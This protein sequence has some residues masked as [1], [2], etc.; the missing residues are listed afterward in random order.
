MG[1]GGEDGRHHGAVARLA[2]RNVPAGPCY[3]H[4]FC[5]CLAPDSDEERETGRLTMQTR[6]DFIQGAASAA[7]AVVFTSCDLLDHHHA[8]AEGARREIV[9][10]GKRVKT[11]DIHAHCA[12]PEANGLLGVK[13]VPGDA[14]RDGGAH[15]VDGRAGHR[16][17]GAEHQ[18]VLVWRQPRRR[19]KADPHPERE[20]CRS[21][22]RAIRI[23]SSPS[24]RSPC[25][26]LTWRFSSS[27]T[28][29]RSSG[30]AACRSAPMSRARSSPIRNSIRSGRSARSSAC[31]CTC[32]RSPMR[33]SRS[34]SPAMAGSST[35]SA[36]RSI[37]PSRSRT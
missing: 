10:S 17:P 13:I 30:C 33:R 9:V 37:P 28:A 19:R 5:G 8:H 18:S 23:A 32:T 36:I 21:R 11:V 29:S 15:Q 12:F 4:R 27:N 7:G 16:R 24:R 6:R 14:Q 31:W 20:A 1:E 35:L 26:I 25:S 34:A 3:G 22:R 2:S